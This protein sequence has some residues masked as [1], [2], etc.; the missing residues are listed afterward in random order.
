MENYEIIETLGGGTFGIVYKAINKKTKQVVAIK[1]F[2]KKFYSFDECKNLREVKSLTKL[3]QHE[4][5][6]KIM[7]MIYREDKS[8]FLVFDYMKEDLLSLM[9][10]RSSK[11]FSEAQIKCIVFQTLKG[12]NYMHKYG[13]FHRDLKPENILVDGDFLKIADFGLAREIRSVP[14]YTDYVSTRWYRAPECLLRSTNYNSPVD[15]WALGCII[16]ELFNFKPIFAGNSE[17]E[18]LYKI[19]SVLGTPSQTTDPNMLTLAKKL[20]FK[21]PINISPPL[22]N[23]I[24]PDASNDAIDFINEM[25]QWEPGRRP[26]AAAL[27]SHPFFTKTSIP[28]RIITPEGEG[29]V[30]GGKKYTS[31]VIKNKKNENN[32]YEISQGVSSNE[33][34]NR[35]LENTQDFN[36]CK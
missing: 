28:T 34:L 14:P 8:L 3:N 2:K 9:K 23:S 33:D 20:D 5:L 17:K 12:I 27:L 22:L 36:E 24:I 16:I 19:C 25:L 29:F 31:N 26:T 30:S 35:F 10:S 1:E 13:F 7:E 6:I 21:F 11:K 32:I 18:V 15:I 4:N